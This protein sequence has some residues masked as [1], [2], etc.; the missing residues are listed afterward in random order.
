MK[1][2]MISQII[3]LSKQNFISGDEYRKISLGTKQVLII[4]PLKNQF[5]YLANTYIEGQWYKVY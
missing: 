1:N 2:K 3:Q 4:E 5:S